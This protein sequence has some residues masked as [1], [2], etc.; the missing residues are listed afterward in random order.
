MQKEVRLVE[1]QNGQLKREVELHSRLEVQYAQK[2]SS[3]A[4]PFD[5][6]AI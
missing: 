1:A 4:C 6:R 5:E 3:Q 2:T